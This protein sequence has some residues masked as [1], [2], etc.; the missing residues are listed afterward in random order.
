MSVVCVTQAAHRLGIDVKTLHHWLAEAQLPLLTHPGDARKKG[1]SDEQLAL[2]ARLHQRRLMGLADELPTPG[3]SA[4]PAWPADLLALS[5]QLGAIQ[6]QLAALQ[7]HV[8]ALTLPLAPQTPPPV[9]P[10]ALGQPG[11]TS[12]RSATAAQSAPG[13]R[14]PAT[15]PRK[16]PHVIARVEYSADGHYVVICPRRGRLS[17]EPESPEWFA[18]LAQQESFRFVGHCG[19]FTAHHWWRVPHGAWRAH[20][21]IRNHSYNVRLAPTPELTIAML[22]QAAAQLQAHLSA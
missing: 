11:K 8:A 17:V 9:S 20:R 19:H 5:E 18:W 7:Q 14:P 6:A 3:A 22:E 4:G 21:H 13:S 15:P 2:L 10:A 16:P 12:K 1:V